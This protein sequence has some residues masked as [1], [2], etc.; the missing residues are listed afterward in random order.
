VFNMP[1]NSTGHTG[2]TMPEGGSGTYMGD[3]KFYG[4]AVGL[5]MSNQQYMVKNVAF[6]GCTTAVVVSHCFD[7]MFQ[8]CSFSNV[9]TGI[10]MS[11][12]GNNNIG[13]VV[14]LDSVGSN[15][16]V[17]V[18]TIDSGTADRSLVL[19][20]VQNSG[21][22]VAV[23]GATVLSGSVPDTW[24]MGN[25][26]LPN[27]PPNG[28]HTSG[29]TSHTPRP[30]VLLDSN[31]NYF[32]MAPP[33]YKENDITQFVNIK[34]V[35]GLPV[36]GDGKT[37]DTANINT[38]LTQ[39]A[40]SKII[41]FPAGTYIVSHT[42]FVPTG[43]RIVGEVW[44]AISAT[45]SVFS[46]EKTPVPMVKV[47]NPGDKGVAQFTDMLFTVAQILPG[48]M[49]VEVNMAGNNPGDVGFWN[50]H[51]RVGGASGSTVQQ[52]CGGPASHCKAAFG[53]IH[54]TKNSSA[55]IEDMWGWTADHDLDA[56]HG[57]SISTGRGCLV[58]AIG[59][60]WLVGT[61][62]EH[63]TLYQYNF[64]N[65]QNVYGGMQQCETP[66]W[67]GGNILT[68]DPWT[69]ESNI[70]DPDFSNCVAGNTQCRMAWYQIIRGC[71]DLFLYSGGFWTFF[72]N[73][74]GCNSC[75]TNAVSIEQSSKVFI[76]GL[77]TRANVN[78]VVGDSGNLRV[79]QQNNPGGWGGA[80]AAMLAN[81][82]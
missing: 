26:Y 20:N 71:S 74:G 70:G 66:Y 39:N 75:Q 16:G 36:Y 40:G 69:P 81:S 64:N 61:A 19:E 29:T 9:G 47:G 25:E 68:P 38:I 82:N 15:V 57:Q 80:V 46:D 58:E 18:N 17:L 7:C 12:S 1:L 43:S 44:S 34:S 48:C 42:I 22:T 67:Q 54:L 4:G 78:L 53:L 30:A 41:F 14:V 24:Y 21:I 31:G 27:G 28:Q 60:T 11:R 62:F 56:G 35:T 63:N 72:N 50:S 2:I 79:A 76:F 65:A 13:S 55:Y 33:T 5:A 8:G 32:T 10:D 23:K 45:G 51:F 52:D 73:G 77:N 6:Q 59:G 37:D 3:L 49:L